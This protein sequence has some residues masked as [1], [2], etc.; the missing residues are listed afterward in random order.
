[1]MAENRPQQVRNVLINWLQKQPVN[2]TR[3]ELFRGLA[4]HHMIF[5]GLED[6]DAGRLISHEEVRRRINEWKNKKLDEEK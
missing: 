3:E 5:K 4:F 1:M 6:S 2:S